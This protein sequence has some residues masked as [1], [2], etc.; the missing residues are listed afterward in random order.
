MSKTKSV[1]LGDIV[2][3]KAGPYFVPAKILYLSNLFKDVILLGVYGQQL[4]ASVMPQSLSHDFAKLLYASKLPVINGKWPVVGNE[5]LLPSQRGMAFRI[6]GGEVY[7]DDC[8]VRIASDEDFKA[9]PSMDVY[10][11]IALERVVANLLDK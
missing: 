11:S 9:L 2:V 6:V 7:L 1:A 3:I 5:D 10:G 4:K 8:V